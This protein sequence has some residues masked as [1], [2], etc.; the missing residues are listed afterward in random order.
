MSHT[1]NVQPASRSRRQVI[2]HAASA[3][4]SLGIFSSLAGA[5]EQMPET[6][7]T[8]PDRARTSLHQEVDL[9]APP[10]AF[11]KSC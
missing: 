3:A 8:G 2:V 6:Q 5:Q 4:A 7:S 10:I 11:T 9:K 1:K